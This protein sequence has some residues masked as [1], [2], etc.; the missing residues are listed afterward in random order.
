M[1]KVHRI[2]VIILALLVPILLVSAA[3]KKKSGKKSKSKKAPHVTRAICVVH[4]L[5]ESK[6]VGVVVFTAKGK[7]VEVTGKITGLTPGKHG[8]HVHEFGDC[9]SKDGMSAGSHFDPEH[10]PHGGPHSEKRHVGDLGNI[11]ADKNGVAEINITDTKIKLNGAHSIIGRSIIV[12]AMEDD[13]K[14]IKSA[15]AR[16]GCG[17]IGIAKG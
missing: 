8:F 13:L 10:M 15:G 6:V 1:P 12:H 2:A 7:K 14:D 5:G 9:T 3:D 11:E 16:I 17:V 4:P